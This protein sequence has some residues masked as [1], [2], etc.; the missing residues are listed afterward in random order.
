SNTILPYN[1]VQT[2][3]FSWSPDSNKIAYISNRSGQRNIWLVNADGSNDVQLTSNSDKNLSLSCPLWSSDGKRIA[4]TSK[5]SKGKAVFGV[6]T[7]DTDTKNSEMMIQADSFLGLIGWMQNGEGLIL[8]S[9]NSPSAVGL[10]PEVFLLLGSIKTGEK[11]QITTLKDTYLYNIH[12][13][14]DKKN[15][16][17]VS[18]R[19][20]KDNIWIMPATGGEAK[21]ITG[22]NDSRLYFS[23]LAWS[24]AGNS[25]FFG[26]QLRYSLLSMLTNF[27]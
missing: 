20:G 13:S 17:F 26:K 2:N 19:E 10:Q 14:P 4:F 21:K 3:D 24:P 8:S 12:L 22:N 9:V 23:G 5:I 15:I 25:I 11:R 1:R 6:W 27:K 16:A 7:I 18:H